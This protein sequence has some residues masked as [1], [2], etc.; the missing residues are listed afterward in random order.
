MEGTKKQTEYRI[1]CSKP[2]KDGVVDMGIFEGFLKSRFKVNGKAGK[3]EEYAIEIARDGRGIVV[4]ARTPAKVYYG[5]KNKPLVWRKKSGHPQKDQRSVFGLVH[6]S[7]C[8]LKYLTRKYLLKHD[9][10]NTVQV[11][12]GGADEYRLEYYAAAEDRAE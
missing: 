11:V 12:S 10:R 8:Y 5:P 1:D 7:K 6:F 4:R 2:A 3:L 9:L